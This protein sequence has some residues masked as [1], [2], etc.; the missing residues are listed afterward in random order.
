MLKEERLLL[1]LLGGAGRD[2]VLRLKLA[3]GLP[4]RSIARELL[5]ATN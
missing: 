5:R 2:T 3:I 4:M 1:L